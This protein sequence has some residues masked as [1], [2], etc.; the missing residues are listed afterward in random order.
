MRVVLN[1]V[2]FLRLYAVHMKKTP[3]KQ[4]KQRILR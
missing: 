2:G 4:L 3:Y 1:L